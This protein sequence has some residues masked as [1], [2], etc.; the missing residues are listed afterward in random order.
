MNAA[1]SA[2]RCATACREH[3]VIDLE[4]L[5]EA[6]P[7]H[8]ADRCAVDQAAMAARG[9]ALHDGEHRRVG[10]IDER[11][12]VAPVERDAGCLDRV[13]AVLTGLFGCSA[14]RQ[15]AHRGSRPLIGAACPNR[16]SARTPAAGMISAAPRASSPMVSSVGASGIAPR[17]ETAAQVGFQAVIPQP[18]AGMRSEPAVSEPSAI[19]TD[20]LAT[21]A[22]RAGRRS[23]GNELVIPRIAHAAMA[24][25]C[26]RTARRR[27]RSAPCSRCARR[28]PRRA[29][30]ARRHRAIH[31]RQRLSQ[32]AMRLAIRRGKD[33]FRRIGHPLQHAADR[34]RVLAECHEG[35]EARLEAACA[36]DDLGPVVWSEC[37]SR[38]FRE[39]QGHLGFSAMPYGSCSRSARPPFRRRRRGVGSLLVQPTSRRR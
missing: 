16:R 5:G 13:D 2:G 17:V 21:A 36:R 33:V 4:T 6:A 7:Q 29:A 25:R 10:G 3:R 35:I 24:P 12:A 18:C 39:A 19:V 32:P 8:R 30:A 14:Q 38:P 15:R 20:P 28:R 27:S 11:E 26:S 31:A 22:G 1:A 37:S 34:G 23:A 9:L